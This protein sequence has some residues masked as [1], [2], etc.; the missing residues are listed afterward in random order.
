ML[1]GATGCMGD[2]IFLFHGVKK[3]HAK[4]SQPILAYPRLSVDQI[5]MPTDL[6]DSLRGMTQKGR[7]RVSDD[8]KD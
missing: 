1:R 4:V 7:S 2:L 3:R 6:N 8:N 5:E